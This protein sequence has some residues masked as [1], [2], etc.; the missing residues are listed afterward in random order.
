MS[1][2]VTAED[3]TAYATVEELTA[4]ATK[5]ELT[6]YVEITDLSDYYTKSETSSATEIGTALEGKQPVGSYLSAET[7]PAFNNWL[8]GDTVIVGYHAQGGTRS[9]ALGYA[10]QATG[11]YSVAIGGPNCFAPANSAIQLGSGYNNTANTF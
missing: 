2:F 1:D 9:I 3:L 4:Y 6:G 11:Q 8:S 5:A 10:T 7:E